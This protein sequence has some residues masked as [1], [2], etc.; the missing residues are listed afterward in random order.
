MGRAAPVTVV[1]TPAFLSAARRLMNDAERALLVDYLAW[2]PTAGDLIPGQAVCASCDG[3]WR[4]EASVV[5]RG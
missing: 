3:R 5:V 1:E 2:N 4:G